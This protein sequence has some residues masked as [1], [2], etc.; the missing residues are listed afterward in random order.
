M[1]RLRDEPIALLFQARRNRAP[2]DWR[3]LRRFR[4]GG[5]ML[6]RCSIPR[7][8]SA[9]G[10]VLRFT[11]AGARLRPKAVL[12]LSMALH[13]L[14]TNAAK[15]GALSHSDGVIELDRERSQPLP[16]QF[17]LHWCE[18][19]GPAVKPPV[20]RGFGSRL[21]ERGLA[22]DLQGTVKLEFAREG[23]EFTLVAPVNGIEGRRRA[24]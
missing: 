3:L 19:G 24:D 13:E 8:A 14:T 2:V 21:I 6:L 20:H 17:R 18:R 10:T 12:A 4:L 11:N 15:H 16:G 1:T 23:V 9:C 5:A 7:G 22:A